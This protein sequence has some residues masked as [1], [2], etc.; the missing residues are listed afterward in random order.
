MAEIKRFTKIFTIA[1]YE[2][3]KKWLE[4]QHAKGWRLIKIMMPFFYTFEK[5][6]PENVIYQLEYKEAD[7]TDD[8]LKMYEDYGWEFFGSYLGWNYFR[9]EAGA[10]ADENDREIF[11]D[12]ES[13]INMIDQVFKTRMIPL[14]TV[15][16]AVMV[17]NFFGLDKLDF[18]PSEIVFTIIYL[19]LLALYI[20]AIFHCAIKLSKMKKELKK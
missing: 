20:W 8:Y 17:P 3:E 2:E 11:S 5:T 19:L 12:A 16:M 9:K 13:K 7:I 15:F 18:S 10:A 6:E 4:N 1:D 14:L